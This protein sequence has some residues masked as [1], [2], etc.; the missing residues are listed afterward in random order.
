MNLIN[1]ILKEAQVKKHFYDRLK[2]RLQG[3]Y[4]DVGVEIRQAQYKVVG[5]YILPSKIKQ[6]I[7]NNIKF[8]EQVSFNVNKSYAIKI[9]QINIPFKEVDFDDSSS[10]IIAKNS[11]NPLVLVDYDTESNGDVIF[12]I[13][14]NNNL[15]TFYWGKSYVPQTKEKMR[16]DVLINDINIIKNKVLKPVS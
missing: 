4:F 2:E 11:R 12:A 15:I 10:E 7:L 1:K 8:L 3:H 14:R 9:G 6:E 5:E 13:I 16:V